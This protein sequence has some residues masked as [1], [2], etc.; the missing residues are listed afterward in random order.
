MS[1]S[2][3]ESSAKVESIRVF[4]RIKPSENRNLCVKP[5]IMRIDDRHLEVDGKIMAYD[6]VFSNDCLQSEVF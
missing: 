4:V 6:H 5:Y 3:F 1:N 2:S